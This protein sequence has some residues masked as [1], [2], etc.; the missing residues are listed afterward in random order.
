MGTQGVN[1]ANQTQRAQLVAQ[2]NAASAKGDFAKVQELSTAILKFDESHKQAA[3]TTVEHN[4]TQP[5][6]PEQQQAKDAANKKALDEIAAM[7]QE[8]NQIIDQYQSKRDDVAATDTT[9]LRGQ[10]KY[11][12]KEAAGEEFNVTGLRAKKIAKA[13]RKNIEAMDNYDAVEKIF[14]NEDEYKAAVKKAKE[15]GTWD[16]DSPKYTLLDGKALE[17]AKTLYQKS[18]ESVNNALNSYH[19]YEDRY[20]QA[21]EAL[22]NPNL[23]D[24]ERKDLESIKN[25]SMYVMMQAA[26]YIQRDYN[27]SQMFNEDGSINKEAYQKTMLQYTGTDFKAGLDER[28]VLKGSAEVK[29]KT[30]KDMFEAAGLDVRK[31]YTGV[32]KAG[33]AALALGTG[34]LTGLLGGG[35]VA[36]AVASA[37][38][39]ATATATASA[40]ATATNQWTASN[41]EEFFDSVE[42][43]D[44]QST[45]VT[46]T[47][48]KISEAAS[49]ISKG[50]MALRGLAGAVLPAVVA[51]ITVKD[52]GEKDAFNGASVQ[53]IISQKAEVSGK[54]NKAIMDKILQTDI[55]GD[56][57]R[58]NEI[59]AAILQTAIGERTGKSANTRELLAAYEAVKFIKDN[60]DLI[61]EGEIS[62]KPTSTPSDSTPTTPEPVTP[63]PEEDCYNVNEE[64]IRTEIPVIKFGGPWHYSKLYVNADGT[65]LSEADRRAVQK[66]LSSGEYAIQNARDDKGKLTGRAMMNELTLP[67]GKK[68]KLADDAVDRANKLKGKGGGKDRKYN[69]ASDGTLMWATDCET[70]KPIS[71]K[72]TPDDFAKWQEKRAAEHQ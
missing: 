50:E 56:P 13:A 2:L 15:D 10:E 6:T 16:K 67:N 44:F 70:G 29:N 35:V 19:K 9:A 4:N 61:G 30:T 51:A 33:A 27:A 62:T 40:T 58:D 49:R 45:T 3:E 39:T 60:K 14:T 52:K 42:A 28:K 25:K 46:S 5:L 68:V 1:G 31:N 38:A 22:Q 34:V 23:T 66:A 18:K 64:N 65:E 71:P 55:T 20:K 32:M 11:T 47:A 53:E 21:D 43:S 7:K 57:N 48:T 63:E 24:N 36:Q 59:K 41:G 26:K 72:M 17:G 12:T 54:A 69:T 8:A 37:T